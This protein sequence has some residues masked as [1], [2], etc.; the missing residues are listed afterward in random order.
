MARRVM[1]AVILSSGAWAQPYFDYRMQATS[2]NRFVWYLDNTTSTMPSGLS[3]AGIQTA[4]EAAWAEWNAVNA[5]PKGAVEARLTSQNSMVQVGSRSDVYSV[6]PTWAVSAS[7]RAY[8]ELL[9]Q[10][11]FRTAVAVYESYDGVLQSC[12]IVL[13]DVNH[14]FSLTG[15]T[16]SNRV[17]VQTV[18][19]HEIG[20]C[21]GLGYLGDRQA[22][23]IMPSV[24]RPGENNRRVGP[25][26]IQALVSRNPPSAAEGAPCGPFFDGGI[27]GGDGG[28]GEGTLRCLRTPLRLDAGFGF[29]CSRG[30]N[31]GTGETCFFPL[32]CQPSSL[33]AGFSG[34]C[35]WPSERSTEIGRACQPG[36][37][38]GSVRGSCKAPIQVGGQDR[39]WLDGYCTQTCLAGDPACPVGST[40]LNVGSSATPDLRCLRNCRPLQNDCRDGYACDPNAN[41]T[42][43]PRC[44][45]DT[46]CPNVNFECRRC[47]GLCV[48]KQSPAG[49]V[50]DRCTSATTCGTG[51]V[52]IPVDQ[53]Q[54]TG[55]VCAEQC[56]AGC[57]TC[58]QGSACE[59][60]PG[61]GLFCVR[62]CNGP[63]TCPSGT[64][65]GIVGG[66]RACIPSCRT[67]TDCAPGEE[68]R[69]D[70]ECYPPDVLP[71]GGCGIFCGFDGGR[72]IVVPGRDGGTGG[73]VVPVCGCTSVRGS[74]WALLLGLWAMGLSRRRSV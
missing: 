11:T 23:D 65:C 51:Q 16:P 71:D 68:C 59:S 42:C 58:P 9:Q 19:L 17:D 63:G 27:G 38:C 46:D 45:L 70:G 61:G 6:M 3:N 14:D 34:A 36:D 67:F 39:Y 64:R 40:C 26:D 1:F 69:S 21:L 12:D 25:N 41:N 28:C 60:V 7:G 4:T 52:C 20:H 55:F 44:F 35:V 47:D 43:I 18:M 56:A 31:T 30:C 8:I 66:S 48:N 33:I 2:S 32:Q 54:P 5:A 50:G 57:G 49:R 73:G 62:Q 10:D 53:N 37:T 13:N 74:W 72:P 22:G 29:F 24:I 15:T